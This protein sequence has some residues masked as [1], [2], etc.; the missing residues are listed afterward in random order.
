MK[1]SSLLLSGIVA[2]LLCHS[3]QGALPDVIF[4]IGQEDH[5]PAEFAL[6]KG[7]G[8]QKYADTFKEPV[9]YTVGKSDA[10][11]A[12]PY[13]HPSV[14]D[15]WAG[16]RTHPFTIRFTLAEKPA[17]PLT[18]I[19]GQVNSLSG[20]TLAVSVNGKAL[21]PVVAPEGAGDSSGLAEG[22]VNPAR[23]LFAIPPDDF[24]AGDNEI[25]ITVEKTSWIIYDFLMLC[26]TPPPPYVPPSIADRAEELRRGD[27][28][29]FDEIVFA[30]RD[31][32]RDG[33]W[34]ANFGYYAYGTERPTDKDDPRMAY[35]SAD[36]GN[37]AVGPVY[38]RQGRLCALNIRTGALRLLVDDPEGT[39]RDPCVS[40][41][42]KK[43][44]FSYRPAGTA[45][46]HLHEINADGSGL[47][48]LT[49]GDFD[50][51]E[52][53][54]HPSGSILFVSTR[55]KR[56]VNCW[57]T[58]VAT[59]HTCRADGSDIRPLSANI[60]QDNTPWPLHDGRIIFTRWEYVDRNQV[61]Y[62]HLWT[63]S[64]DGTQHSVFYGNLHPGGLYIDAKPIPG[65]VDVIF[66]DSP[67]HGAME[68]QGFVARVSAKQGPDARES[69]RRISKS[70]NFRDPWALAD[71]LYLA[72]RGRD[73]VLL[74]DCGTEEILHTLP[75]LVN[76]Q[77]NEHLHG[78]T[79]FSSVR[80]A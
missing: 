77:G 18:F 40:Y 73:L 16:S 61:S 49:D 62:H 56:W 31:H 36:S 58:Q 30:T 64:P 21:P 20:P 17:A 66:I 57:V 24:T 80:E 46:Y 45:N 26:Q 6:A 48:R 70:G 29:A 37:L 10:K 54:Y 33:H 59:I 52:P 9:V 39:V 1:K 3:G 4:T 28:G 19:V 41:D 35:V 38:G 79:Y 14:H 55:L 7:A 76:L 74:N 53:C 65:S 71:D 22:A 5:S 72:A 13:I 42:A 34:Y 23:T 60:E 25:A 32:Y 43:I 12:W 15:K 11:K 78:T 2:V 47:T 67:G 68:H 63:M 8:W 44:L 69:L 75:A 51:I 27:Y 50:D